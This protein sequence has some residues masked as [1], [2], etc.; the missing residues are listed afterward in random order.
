MPIT[1]TGL[2]SGLDTESII[3]QLMQIEQTKVTAVQKRQVSV[4]QHKTDLQ[5]VKSKLDAF[6]TAA[7][8]LGNASLWKIVD[9]ATPPRLP[10]PSAAQR[11]LRTPPASGTTGPA[12]GFM[13]RNTTN[14]ARSS[15][16]INAEAFRR[17]NGVSTTVIG[18]ASI[19]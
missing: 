11:N 10:L 15:S 9:D 6:K 3:S 19:S 2:A 13:P 8:D 1:L 4:N 17:K 5:M 14:S 7:T 12:S 16:A 18:T